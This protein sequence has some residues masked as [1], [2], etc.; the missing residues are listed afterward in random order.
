MGSQAGG[1][2]NRGG[3]EAHMGVG[4]PQSL[5]S[6]SRTAS[7]RG[8][9]AGRLVDLL[10]RSDFTLGQSLQG[11]ITCECAVGLAALHRAQSGSWLDSGS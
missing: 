3:G 4:R 9:Y 7:N 8:R 1:K 6:G 11:R 5:F 10:I 2:R